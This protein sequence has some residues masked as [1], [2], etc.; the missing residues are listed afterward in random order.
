M[1]DVT[2]PSRGRLPR[3]EPRPEVQL[4]GLRSAPQP[5]VAPPRVAQAEPD[6]SKPLDL[7]VAETPERVVVPKGKRHWVKWLLV[8]LAL[9][10]VAVAAALFAGYSW[11][12]DA[13]Q[14]RSD[15][16]E[17]IKVTVESGETADM[18]ATKLE[19]KGVIK[20]ALAVQIYVKLNGKGNIKAGSYMFSPNQPPAEILQWLNDGRVDTFKVTILPGQTLADIKNALQKYGYA[21][22]EIDAA[23]ARQYSHPLLADKP[24][25]ATL[26]GYL[27]P[28]TYF[29]TSDTTVEQLLVAAFDEFEKQVTTKNLRTALAQQKFTLF[30]G[31]VLASIIEKEVTREPDQRQVA[32]VFETRLKE[33]MVLGSDVTYHYAAKMLGIAPNPDIDSPYNT[34]KFGGLPPGAIANFHISALEAVANPAQGDYLFFVAGDDG[35]THFSRTNAEHEANVRQYCKKLCSTF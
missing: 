10:L 22:E 5:V 27:Y 32:Q 18:I 6:L 31:V 12:Q 26:E 3:P 16:S 1:N 17:A 15:S 21:A 35:T 9:L 2:P 20:S 23:F 33:G 24:P 30:Q 4:K 34:R 13:L 14:A 28:E 25:T 8:V 29:V 11:Y 19:Q 7:P